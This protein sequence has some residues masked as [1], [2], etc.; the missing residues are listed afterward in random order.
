MGLEHRRMASYSLKRRSQ[1]G[2]RREKHS[3]GNVAPNAGGPRIA[4]ERGGVNVQRRSAIGALLLF[5]FGAMLLVWATPLDNTLASPG[6]THRLLLSNVKP[7]A[8]IPIQASRSAPAKDHAIPSDVFVAFQI[9]LKNRLEPINR[10]HVVLSTLE[11]G[12]GMAFKV[13]ANREFRISVPG[14]TA[15]IPPFTFIIS[16]KLPVSKW[17]TVEARVTRSQSLR[18][19]LTGRTVTSYT[20]NLPIWAAMPRLLHVTGTPSISIRHVLVSFTLDTAQPKGPLWLFLRLGQIIGAISVVAGS[21]LLA[22]RYLGSAIAVKHP[23]KRLVQVAFGTMGAFELGNIALDLAHPYHAPSPYL[24]WNSWL[25]SQ[26]PRFNDFFQVFEIL[27]SRI[28]YGVRAGSYPPFGY[29]LLLPVSWL[30]EYAALYIF[31]AMCIGF[32]GF[33][34]WRNFAS[35][36][37]APQRLAIMAIGLL[38]LPVTFGVDR[39]NIDLAIFAMAAI[40]IEALRQDL[41]YSGS[42]FLGIAAAAKVFP[43]M[44]L[45]SLFRKRNGRYLLF[46]VVVA[47]VVTAASFLGLEGTLVQNVQGFLRGQIS[48]Q[49][50]LGAVQPSTYYNTSIFACLQAIALA[51][52][53][54]SAATAIHARMAGF[55]LPGEVLAVVG[56]A[57][58]IWKVQTKLWH[59]VAILTI[60]TL[61]F[62]QLSNYY[63]LL[64]VF[65]PLM[66]MV[67][68]ETGY[69]KTFAI[70][71]LYG[72]VLAPRA[73]WYISGAVDISVVT[74]APALV[75][76]LVLVMSDMAQRA[77]SGPSR[78]EASELLV[79]AR[80]RRLAR[81]REAMADRQ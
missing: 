16:Q 46:G 78:L 77:K 59:R 36:F 48:L 39:A 10:G 8:Q 15:T 66:L 54:V 20:W 61:L 25:F 12:S 28:P 9:R 81:S 11:R 27:K 30:H 40:G 2:T 75:A 50:Q 67:T 62:F 56:S 71:A 7:A 76:V 57:A 19:E 1:H 31:L 55:V 21:V 80:P 69:G 24:D 29:W 42:M 53:G 79:R 18:V 52:G 72:F 74:T 13:A 41:N 6:P 58:L 33:W 63:E 23:R 60:A 17:L 65:L 5:C 22:R 32:I 49:H 73:W 47:L 3:A 70:A 38:S 37:S 34:I 51:I 26:Y 4:G 64:F 45:L 43:G 68:Q 14:E 35:T 44:Y